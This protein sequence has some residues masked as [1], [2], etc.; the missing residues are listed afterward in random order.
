MICAA[1]EDPGLRR[2]E[3]DVKDA[4][5][6][7]HSVHLQFFQG[8]DQS[9]LHHVAEDLPVEHIDVAWIKQKI[10]LEI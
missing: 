4:Q 9:V 2:V 8:N 3:G 1:A 10:K 7:L 5:V 6:F